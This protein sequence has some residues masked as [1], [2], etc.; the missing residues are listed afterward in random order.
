MEAPPEGNKDANTRE[1]MKKIARIIDEELP[2]G[3]GFFILTF[4]FGAAPGRMNYVANAKRE[5]V[6]RLMKE[7]IT[8]TEAHGKME[9]HI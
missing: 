5:D 7:F 1:V 6:L 8:K 2:Q 9:G 4:P 3:W